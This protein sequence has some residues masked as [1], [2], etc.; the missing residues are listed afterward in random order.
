MTTMLPFLSDLTPEM[1]EKAPKDQLYGIFRMV[2]T[3][4]DKQL[5]FNYINDPEVDRLVTLVRTTR[6]RLVLQLQK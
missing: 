3:A 2:S 4:L 6:N 5:A 1:V